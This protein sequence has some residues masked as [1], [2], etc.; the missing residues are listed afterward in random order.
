LGQLEVTEVKKK[1][2]GNFQPSKKAN[3]RKRLTTRHETPTTGA[4]TGSD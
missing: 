4:E 3:L 1:V 2:D